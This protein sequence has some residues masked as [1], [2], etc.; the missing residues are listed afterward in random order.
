MKLNNNNL[1]LLT[2]V[3]TPTY[4]RSE[5]T[6]G[7]IHIGM[8][9]FHRAHQAWYLHRLMQQNQCL[10]WGVLGAS[11]RS[12]DNAM[13]DK[14]LAQDGLT[15]LIEL[16]P[17]KF[18][19]EVI[20]SIIG[21]LPIQD[22]NQPLIDAMTQ[23][24]IKIVSLTI[25]EGGYY[26]D[27]GSRS[28]D[29]NHPDIIHDIQNPTS[30][31]PCTAFG[32]IIRALAIR[33]HAGTGPFTVM[34]CDNLLGNGDITK[35]IIL[36]LANHI[37]TELGAWI[38]E[39]VTFPNSMVDCIVPATGANELAKV[40]E[41]GID[42]Q[43]P[44]THESF[45]QW[46]VEDRFCAGRPS[47]DLVGVTFTDDVHQYEVLKIR[48]LNGGHQVIAAAGDLIGINTISGCLANP[49]IE[50]L[51]FAAENEIVQHV[52]SVPQWSTADY[53]KL[54]SKRFG[55]P[56]IVDTTRRVAFDG[57]SRQAGFIVPSIMDSLNK[58]TGFPA[59]A[60]T[61]AVWARYCEGHR[62][63][64]SAIEANDPHWD[65]LLEQAQVAK[66]TPATWLQ[67]TRVYGDIADHKGFVE[68][69]SQC[70]KSIYANGLEDTIH[71][72]LS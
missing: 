27:A 68:Q 32:A 36:T 35:N 69:F 31:S 29:A 5:L 37:D 41:H 26:F 60:L 58:Q 34:S 11:V 59:L 47:W 28:F 25:T 6:S 21:F 57:S 19:T 48:V 63:D 53:I 39:H 65:E 72:V 62:E 43:V 42:D 13:R 24:N 23:A 45:R 33:K 17:E 2:D 61:A 1:P 18:D 3:L 22:D 20:G 8:G 71:S 64:G 49:A 9:N 70:L 56:N 16:G 46:V 14:L 40:Q 67:N 51:F 54:V 50:K 66:A 15:T 55:N 4:N 38:A 7:I 52:Q 30:P 10:N 12:A 44:V